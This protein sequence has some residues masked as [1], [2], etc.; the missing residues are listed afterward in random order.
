M[1]ADH[2]D[3][4]N[5]LY[6]QLTG[7][8]SAEQEVLIKNMGLDQ[9][10]E[11]HLRKMLEADQSTG[12]MSTPPSLDVVLE[13]LQ[14][15]SQFGSYRIIQEMATGGMGRVFKAQLMDSDVPIFTALK[16]IRAELKNAH[17]ENRFLHEKNI[18]SKL[19]HNHIATLMDAGV[20][21]T[22]VPYIATQWIDGQPIDVYCRDQQ[23]NLDARLHLFLQVCE[24]VEY[25]H[26]QLII[27][28]DLKPANILVDHNGHVKLLDFGIAKLLDDEQARQTQTQMFTPDYAAPEQIQ[29]KACT[30][31]TDVYALGVLLYELLTGEKRFDQ[32]NLS[33]ADRIA[34]IST[35]QTNKASDTSVA[36]DHPVNTTRLRGALDTI[37]NTAMHTET[38]RRYQS[39][40]SL[41]EDIRRYRSNL[42]IQAMDDSIW[43]RMRMF[44]A[45]NTLATVLTALVFIS[46]LGGLL[47]VSYQR[48][49]ALKAQ[50]QAEQQSKKSA[51]ML[52][53]FSKVLETAS[54]V[55]GGSTNI[56]VRDMFV[57]GAEKFD[58][59]AIEDPE[60]QAEIAAEV[61]FIYNQL[62]E[63]ATAEPY[64][65]TAIKHY[66]QRLPTHATEFLI[67]A[68]RMKTV[69]F[70]KGQPQQALDW[71]QGALDNTEPYPVEGNIKA[72]ALINI[73]Q[74]NAE[75]NQV[76][77]A[78][79]YYDEAEQLAESIQHHES[80]GKVNYY[81]RI[82]LDEKLSSEEQMA[83]LEKSRLHF[84]K[85]FGDVHPTLIAVENSLAI[86][87][88]DQGAYLQADALFTELI[89]DNAALYGRDNSSHITN[90]ADTKFYLG[91]FEQ[92][93]ELATEA[94]NL[95][96]QN[97]T[98]ES[99]YS[100]AAKIIKARSLTELKRYS[101][102]EALYDDAVAFFSEKLPP[103]HYIHA[104][105]NSYRVDHYLKSNQ[106]QK[107]I[108]L[109]A[110][111]EAQ[112]EAQLSDSPGSRRIH[113]N[114]LMVL[115]S[116]ELQQK[117]FQQS[118]QHFSKASDILQQYMSNES[119]LY[120]L[121][122]SGRELSKQQL[123][124]AF[125]PDL[126]Q[127]AQTQL[128]D[129][130]GTDHW[131][132]QLFATTQTGHE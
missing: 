59:E 98:E 77:T 83:M 106:V 53:F 118:L 74:L 97:Q 24:A 48:Q 58:I 115:G 94:I 126:L 89:K 52:S 9:H 102:A 14:E 2:W 124:Q 93:V 1:N 31:A 15:D 12:F 99:F 17:L 34:L 80:I 90:H 35:P 21:D 132:H 95:L 109:S 16:L 120:W 116:L 103:S 11:T 45:R 56:T 71:L 55:A 10:M 107:A 111:L 125:D 113:M 23:L 54:P 47:L 100:I 117:N 87:L 13:T 29:G 78:L 92:G 85:A 4:L 69:L 121:A 19:Q 63:Y 46:L 79:T 110:G 127:Q 40:S 128:F 25:A 84:G 6:D 67:L 76:E 62:D 43:Y 68:L 64:L 123:Q 44:A 32:K 75:L 105:L 81:R 70:E 42:P 65:K 7:L 30:T 73:G 131:Y 50:H 57:K 33:L 18:L 122:Q 96:Q 8:D 66:E 114:I 60:L 72:E 104:V 91:Q 27:H 101:E 51:Q 130:I 61:S 37:I 22:G 26:Q 86:L 41:I 3:K 108:E 20:T 5:Q 129:Q 39:V 28:R 88:K 36:D 119:W 112:G 49:E 38:E 82:L